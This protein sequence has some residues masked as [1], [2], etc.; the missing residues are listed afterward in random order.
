MQ[1]GVASP[2]HQTYGRES[3]IK[4]GTKHIPVRHKPRL[5]R[6]CAQL[7][8]AIRSSGVI[9]L[10]GISGSAG[11]AGLGGSAAF[12]VKGCA[13]A[14]A[15]PFDGALA[16]APPGMGPRAGPSADREI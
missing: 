2:V 11:G 13:A 4:M 10:I 7:N 16:G 3:G 8:S 6:S 14:P 12:L 5:V 15:G 1:S 9:D